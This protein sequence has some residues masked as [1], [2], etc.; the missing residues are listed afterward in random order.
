MFVARS[1][2]RVSQSEFDFASTLSGEVA[3]SQ[4]GRDYGTDE[5]GKIA[6]LCM[7]LALFSPKILPIQNKHVTLQP[8]S[9]Q[10]ATTP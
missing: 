5:L 10:K 9:Q 2:V 6:L 7:F 4:R 3:E 8:L 1:A